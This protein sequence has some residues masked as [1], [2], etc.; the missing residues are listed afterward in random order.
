MKRGWFL[1][2]LRG[3]DDFIVQLP[4]CVNI[5]EISRK[6]VPLNG[7]ETIFYVQSYQG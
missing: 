5:F 6:T 7:H 1:K 3:S 2:F 4:I